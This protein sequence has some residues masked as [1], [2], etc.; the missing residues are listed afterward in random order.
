MF[1][2]TEGRGGGQLMKAK[3][4]EQLADRQRAGQEALEKELLARA[5]DARRREVESRRKAAMNE[6]DVAKE[7]NA[8][9]DW[10]MK[11][12]NPAPRVDQR[13]ERS[14][15]R[16]AAL[17]VVDLSPRELR[18]PDSSAADKALKDFLSIQQ[19]HESGRLAAQRN[20][21]VTQEVRVTRPPISEAELM[22]AAEA[23]LA[24][25]ERQARRQKMFEDQEMAERLERQ[26]EALRVKAEDM[27]QRHDNAGKAYDSAVDARI[28]AGEQMRLPQPVS[29]RLA[30][31]SGVSDAS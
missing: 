25:R 28:H 2:R 12:K 1:R 6:D 26:R 27:K 5:S 7:M 22:A 23:A 20:L 8:F 19:N 30:D 11:L 15:G 4:L 29:P 17:E 21:H 16:R 14:E 24:V 9:H 18:Q 10:R 13:G 3:L 31:F